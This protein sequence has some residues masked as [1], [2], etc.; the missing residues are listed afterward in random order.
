MTHSVKIFTD[1]Y[2][3]A[4]NTVVALSAEGP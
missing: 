3:T 4:L 2:C 1:F